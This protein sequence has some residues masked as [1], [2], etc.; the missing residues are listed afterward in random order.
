MARVNW[1]PDACSTTPLFFGRNQRR[2]TSRR[3]DGQ[4]VRLFVSGERSNC[5]RRRTTRVGCCARAVSNAIRLISGLA[6][7]SARDLV[8]QPG[9]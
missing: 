3:H 7:P 4:I 1:Q 9:L 8:P 6:N 5:V 2:V